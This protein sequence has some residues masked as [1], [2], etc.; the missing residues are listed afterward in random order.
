[1]PSRIRARTC[2]SPASRC[3]SAIASPPTGSA[4]NAAAPWPARCATAVGASA[5]AWP[6][7]PTPRTAAP[8]T[9]RRGCCPTAVSSFRSATH[10]LGTGTYTVMSQVAADAIG[11]PVAKVR[12]ELGD[13]RLP[14]APGAGGS[15]SAAS[16]SPRCMRPGWRC[17]KNSSSWPSPIRSRSPTATTQRR[18]RSSTAGFGRQPRWSLGR[19]WPRRRLPA[20]RSPPSCSATA[21]MRSRP[22]RNRSPAPSANSIRCIRSAPSSSKSE[23]TP[24]SASCACRG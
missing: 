2:R 8:P 12:F 18:S 11:V 4:G 17:G 7:P 20:S 22:P 9:L 16:V 10:D 6:R 1:M 19:R 5:T 21:A 24:T 15:Q 3:A 13:S 14:K 23:S